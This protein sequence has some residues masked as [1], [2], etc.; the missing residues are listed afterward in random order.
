MP[1]WVALSIACAIPLAVSAGAGPS[2]LV[3]AGT[4]R[5]AD[6]DQAVARA[7]VT[8]HDAGAAA[9]TDSA[10]AFR[11]SISSFPAIVTIERAGYQSR[12]LTVPTAA[13]NPVEVRLIPA[14]YE[15]AE[16]LVKYEDPA[17]RI[18]R[19]VL[20]RK[21]A[22]QGRL[23]SWTAEAYTRQTLYANTRIIAIREQESRWFSDRD[24]GER[25]VVLAGHHSVGVPEELRYFA[26]RAYFANL[27]DDEIEIVGQ[28][29][30]GPT[31]PEALDHYRFELTGRKPAGADTV[32]EIRAQPRG[33]LQTALAGYLLVRQ[34]DFAMVEAGLTVAPPVVT[35]RVPSRDGL[36]LRFVQHFAASGDGIWLPLDLEYEID[37]HLGTSAL[38]ERVLRWRNDATPRAR[39][40]GRCDL[41]KHRVNGR[42]SDFIFQSPGPLEV[43][44]LAAADSLVRPER[45]AL[46]PREERAYR[47]LARRPSHLG[48]SPAEGLFALY[49][50]LPRPGADDE[51]VADPFAAESLVSDEA[52][53]A[54]VQQ[55]L[56]LPVPELPDGEW[57][58]ELDPEVWYNRV[59]GL[60]AGGRARILPGHG[61]GFFLKGGYDV[62]LERLY[63]GASLSLGEVT[64]SSPEE[65]AGHAPRRVAGLALTVS[66]E[67]GVRTTYASDTYTLAG[68][69]FPLLLGIDDY[70]DYYWSR[71]WRAEISGGWGGRRVPSGRQASG[72]GLS[73]TLGANLEEHRSLAKSTSFDVLCDFQPE[74]GRFYGLVCED[75]DHTLRA[76]PPIRPGRLHSLDLRAEW[77]GPYIPRGR[78]IN[79]R[80]ELRA[81][82]AGGLVG[83][84][85]DFRRVEATVDGH[86][87][88]FLRRRAGSGALDVRLVG[89]VAW[90]SMPPQ[91]LGALD[92]AIW[93]LTPF[94]GFRTRRDRPLAG[95]RY[96]GLFWEHDFGAAPLELLRLRGLA[97]AGHGLI[98]H[99]AS[100]GVRKPRGGDCHDCGA[101]SATHHELGLS[102]VVDGR[103][104]VDA[105][106]R[107]DQPGWWV[108]LSKVRLGR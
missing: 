23:V 83:G 54:A 45:L 61:A 51:A 104:R 41:R 106:R 1:I 71:S 102:W 22:W 73:L 78:A 85:F 96:A 99:G 49:P 76:N 46:T 88:T 12:Q 103:W 101:A 66:H 81:E 6:T 74:S 63:G 5:D 69:S 13:A 59:E 4:V 107:L 47:R 79:R 87:D 62:G 58:P 70:F 20:R 39:L 50:G 26:A 100:G 77:G 8:L 56:G 3:V 38:G 36:H 94:G 14:P 37:A 89:G 33:L 15:M 19:E 43:D 57:V 44:G 97:K 9:L 60:H 80:A 31:H 40:E 18:M 75:R 92:A 10:G 67:A 82:Y 42:I 86:W 28:R 55:G 30:V 91:R 72:A 2:R 35:S 95:E 17:M 52:V 65:A 84:D 11:L 68:N 53:V 21:E 64:G 7:A 16:T 108:G 105:T 25:E 32:Y 34:S 90:G 48:R 98:L 27:Y 29:V 93:R 24:R